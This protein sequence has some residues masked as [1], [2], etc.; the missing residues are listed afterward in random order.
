MKP[1]REKDWKLLRSMKDEKLALFCDRVFDRLDDIIRNKGP[2]SHKAY[3]R[4]WK[5]LRSEDHK[6]ADMF[7][8]LK[9][10]NALQKLGAWRRYELLDD[11]EL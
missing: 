4:L 8:E 6:I 9:R 10:S 11:E 1:I 2:E 3:K 7:D 5:T